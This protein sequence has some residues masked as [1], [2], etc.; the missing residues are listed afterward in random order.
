MGDPV[1]VERAAHSLSR[2]Q[3]DQDA[4][5]VLYRLHQNSHVA[6]LV[7]GFLHWEADG[8]EVERGG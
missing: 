1:I 8:G 5:K 7:G 6:Y 4:L 2:S 3:I